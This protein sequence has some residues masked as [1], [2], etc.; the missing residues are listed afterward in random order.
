MT[1]RRHAKCGRMNVIDGCVITA[2]GAL[3][4]QGEN[5]KKDLSRLVIFVFFDPHGIVDE[6]VVRLLQALR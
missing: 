6:Y 5:M 2:Y 4:V 1:S 3:E